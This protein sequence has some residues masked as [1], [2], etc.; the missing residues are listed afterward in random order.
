M[1]IAIFR[2]IL[3]NLSTFV[4]ATSF[5]TSERSNTHE[6]GIPGT[7]RNHTSSFHFQDAS[8]GLAVKVFDYYTHTVV[9]TERERENGREKEWDVQ[10]RE[11]TNLHRNK[12]EF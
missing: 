6:L 1:V 11:E 4:H 3:S 12:I 5:T 7:L 2:R 10:I 9:H 8:N